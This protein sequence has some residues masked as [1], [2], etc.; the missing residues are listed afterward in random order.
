MQG[1]QMLELAGDTQIQLLEND[2]DF[3]GFGAVTVG[4]IALR[5]GA[6]PIVIRVDTPTGI[7]YTRLAIEKI[8]R[9]ESG[10][11]IALDAIGLPWGRCE[12]HDEYGQPLQG[13]V[14]LQIELELALSLLGRD[15]FRQISDHAQRAFA[16]RNRTQ[17][18]RLGKSQVAFTSLPPFGP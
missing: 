16:R 15:A 12:Y 18:A 10:V 11:E 8:E 6:R 3:V 7:L 17:E 14:A 5:N 2:G 4:G 1:S 13:L 9:S